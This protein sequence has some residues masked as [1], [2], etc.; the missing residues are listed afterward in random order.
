MQIAVNRTMRRLKQVSIDACIAWLA[1]L[2]LISM[3]AYFWFMTLQ[4]SRTNA[5]IE[6]KSNELLTKKN[7]LKKVED[8]PWYIKFLA[9]KYLETETKT[10]NWEQSLKYLTSLLEELKAYNKQQRSVNL[11]NFQI[12][13]KTISLEW[14][15]S[16]LKDIYAEWWIIDRFSWYPFIEFFRVPYYRQNTDDGGYNFLLNADIYHY[17]WIE[18]TP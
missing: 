15:V 18:P 2:I 8:H 9:A 17:D 7:E 5:L 10:V 6:K 14:R 16:A 3:V 1:L 13:E 4:L 11:A 12:N